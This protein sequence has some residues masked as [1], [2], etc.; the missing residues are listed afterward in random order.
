MLF[1]GVSGDDNA[2][3]VNEAFAAGTPVPSLDQHRGAVFSELGL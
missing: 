3:H 1:A 2:V